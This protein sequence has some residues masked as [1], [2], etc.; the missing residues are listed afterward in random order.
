MYAEAS[1]GEK[2]EIKVDPENIE[3]V[4]RRVTD[5][6]LRVFMDAEAKTRT[7][8]TLPQLL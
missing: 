8:Q 1:K 2:N 7:L 6:V 4:T 3:E 5:T